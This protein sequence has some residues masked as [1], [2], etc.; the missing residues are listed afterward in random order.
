MDTSP[1]PELALAGTPPQPGYAPLQVLF[2]SGLIVRSY[3]SSLP[4][5]RL[6]F[7]LK[8]V[9]DLQRNVKDVLKSKSHFPKFSNFQI[10]A[11]SKLKKFQ[12]F[13]DVTAICLFLMIMTIAFFQCFIRTPIKQ[14]QNKPPQHYKTS[15]TEYKFFALFTLSNF[16]PKLMSFPMG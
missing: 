11:F 9:K 5:R 14:I 8:N 2:E 3:T 1:K 13:V 12:N 7:P 4:L 6:T 16:I 15:R 10:S